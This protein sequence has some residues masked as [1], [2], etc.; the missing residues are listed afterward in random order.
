MRFLV[1][2]IT[3]LGVMIASDAIWLGLSYVP[4]YQPQMA[5]LLSAKPN[6]AAASA[7]YLL[8]ALAL[9][10]LIV[11]PLVKTGQTDWPSLLWRAALFGLVTYGTYDLTGLAVISYW[12]LPLSLIDMAWGMVITLFGAAGAALAVSLVWRRSK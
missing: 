8:Y 4:L 3:T 11:W 12:P 6:L 2:V 1:C 5:A 7:F 9:N 10:A